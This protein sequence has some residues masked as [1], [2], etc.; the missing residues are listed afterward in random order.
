MSNDLEDI[1]A[2][3]AKRYTKFVGILIGFSIT[4]AVIIITLAY[5]KIPESTL[6]SY[7]LAA[8]IYSALA[9][10]NTF[11]WY[12]VATEKTEMQRRA[13]LYGTIFYYTGYWGILLGL[14]YLTSLILSP[15]TLNYPFLIS[16]AFLG[17]TFIINGYEFVWNIWKGERSWGIIFLVLL[18]IPII[19]SFLTIPKE[20]V[21]VLLRMLNPF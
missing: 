18:I 15:P 4:I 16:L 19:L 14:V 1:L 12:G 6:Y 21:V 3:R 17:Y 9:F 2:D 20:P 11:T 10:F 7:S 5:E 8:F 13:F